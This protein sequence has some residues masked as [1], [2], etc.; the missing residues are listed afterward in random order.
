MSSLRQK[1]VQGEFVFTVELEP[2][3]GVGMDK[4]LHSAWQHQCLLA[5]G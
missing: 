4:L 2:P 1:I 5:K 3:K